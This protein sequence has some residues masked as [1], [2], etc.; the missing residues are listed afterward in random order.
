MLLFIVFFRIISLPIF[1]EDGKTERG[2]T[3]KCLHCGHVYEHRRVNLHMYKMHIRYNRAQYY[4]SSCTFRSTRQKDLV[5]H[6]GPGVYRRHQKTVDFLRL[7]G[8][9][10]DESYMLMKCLTLKIPMEGVDF[11]RL[12]QQKPQAYGSRRKGLLSLLVMFN[13]CLVRAGSREH[14]MR[15]VGL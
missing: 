13:R 5:D 3:Y 12:S 14:Y 11:F 9:Q 4:Y 7:Q 2:R 1:Q 6:S 15:Y 8:I 10:V